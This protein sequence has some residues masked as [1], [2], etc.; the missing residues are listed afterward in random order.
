MS[1]EA[2]CDID[3]VPLAGG[4]CTSSFLSPST[5]AHQRHQHQHQHLGQWNR[6]CPCSGS[7]ATRAN[8]AR[9]LRTNGCGRLGARHLRTPDRTPDRTPCHAMSLEK[10]ASMAVSLTT[11]LRASGS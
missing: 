10:M 6:R 2:R 8:D 5:I 9:R 7:D 1:M 4:P 3:D 11:R